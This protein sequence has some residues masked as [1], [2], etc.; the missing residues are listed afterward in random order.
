[1][2]FPISDQW[3][4]RPYLLLFPRYSQFSV[5]THIFPTHPTFNPKYTN[6]PL[7]LHPQILY[8]E[9]LDTELI[10]LAKKFPLIP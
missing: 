10:I 9:S 1:M 6:I 7:E 8:A 3:Q 2:Q 4:P 5:K